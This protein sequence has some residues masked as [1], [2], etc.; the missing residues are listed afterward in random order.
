MRKLTKHLLEKSQGA[1]ILSVELYNKPTV[2]YRNESFSMLFTNAWELLLK[3][4]IYEDSGG[5]LLSIF[6]PKARLAKRQ[7]ITIDECF[8]KVFPLEKDPIRNNI[9]FISEIR[10]E[11]THLIISEF[12]PYYSRV[13]QSGV[14]NYL[15]KI[16]EWF[17]VEASKILPPGFLALVSYERL[18]DMELIKKKFNSEDFKALVEWETRFSK[19][20]E[21][22][23]DAAI[24]ISHQIAL[25]KNPKKADVILNPGAEGTGVTI[26]ERSRDVDETHP[27]RATDV[28]NSVNGLL[29]AKTINTYDLQSYLYAHGLKATNNEH[30]WKTKFNVDQY[31]NEL[32]SNLFQA[33]EQD[34]TATNKWRKQYSSHMRQRRR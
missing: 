22:G 30:H 31:S 3:A 8:D 14:I 19:L 20:Q 11:A 27:N 18:P 16:E 17:S 21:L 29:T 2:A 28:I 5:K 7:S 15:K 12:D 24:S 1:F 25:V 13:F 33:I 9:L 32:I 6:R 26:I 10:N 23:N 4:K 34:P